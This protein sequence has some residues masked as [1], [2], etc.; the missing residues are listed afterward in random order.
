MMPTVTI[1]NSKATSPLQ[2]VSPSLQSL[3]SKYL[4]AVRDLLSDPSNPPSLGH[5]SCDD[6]N[7]AK[8]ADNGC[9]AD[10]EP[11]GVVPVRQG[12]SQA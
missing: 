5:A 6:G 10:R 2:I 3:N 8:N 12:V 1:P 11:L 9:N 4:L 7:T